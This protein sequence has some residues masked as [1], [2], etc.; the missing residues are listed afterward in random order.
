MICTFLDSCVSKYGR[1]EEITEALEVG[2]QSIREIIQCFPSESYICSLRVQ[3]AAI[4]AGNGKIYQFPQKSAY[5]IYF[6]IANDVSADKT[7]I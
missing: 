6:L 7:K 4:Q 2:E 1:L 5:F 3:L